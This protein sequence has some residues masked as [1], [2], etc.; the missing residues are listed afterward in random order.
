VLASRNQINFL[1]YFEEELSKR[2]ISYGIDQY[3]KYFSSFVEWQT[4]ALLKKEKKRV[5]STSVL[6]FRIMRELRKIAKED[7]M[8]VIQAFLTPFSI[9][10]KSKWDDSFEERINKYKN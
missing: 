7:P 9:Y 1:K 4:V 3:H 6:H 10:F 5:N 2:W 8:S